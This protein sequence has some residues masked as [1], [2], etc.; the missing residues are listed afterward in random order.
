MK[1][2]LI[3]GLIGLLAVTA[4]ILILSDSD[5]LGLLILS[6]VIG[7]GLLYASSRV[8]EFFNGE[9]MV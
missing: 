3:N 2:H 9:E 8:Y 4:V 1:Q 5:K 7:I 6:K